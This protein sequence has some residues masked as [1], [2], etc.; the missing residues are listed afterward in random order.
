MFSF[1]S[2]FGACEECNGLGMKMKV[3]EDLLM[4]DKNKSIA[5]GGIVTLSN[6]QNTM[7]TEVQTVADYYDIDLNMPIKDIPKEKLNKI[8]YG[9]TTPLEFTYVSKNGNVRTKTDFLKE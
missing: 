8:L 5:Q 1:N 9:S 2:P 6:D 4:P 7:Y 3:S